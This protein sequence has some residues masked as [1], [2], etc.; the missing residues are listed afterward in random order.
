MNFWQL[1]HYTEPKKHN[2]R[3]QEKGSTTNGWSVEG[4]QKFNEIVQQVKIDRSKLGEE[5]DK[6]F[7]LYMEAKA[8]KNNKGKQKREEV[9]TYNDL[10]G[11][12]GLHDEG[13][14]NLNLF[15][16]FD[17]RDLLPVKEV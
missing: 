10:N 7:K 12:D 4:L 11:S 2:D 9:Y 8:T 1:P 16:D 3:Q 17:Q 5:F 6:E 15:G 14:E 13:S